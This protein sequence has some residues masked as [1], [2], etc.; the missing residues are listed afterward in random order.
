MAD[1]MV[2]DVANVFVN[3]RLTLGACRDGVSAAPGGGLLTG[4]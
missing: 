1:E 3:L 4:R 2:G